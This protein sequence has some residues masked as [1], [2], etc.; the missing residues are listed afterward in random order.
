MKIEKSQIFSFVTTVL[1]FVMVGHF[2]LGVPFPKLHWVKSYFS[3]S[4]TFKSPKKDK[5]IKPSKTIIRATA[6]SND[7][8]VGRVVDQFNGVKVYSNGRVTNI[9]G[10]NVTKDGYNLGLKYQCVEFVKR[11]YYEYYHHK[12]PDSYGNAKDFFNFDVPDG[13]YNS[14]RGLYQFTN[15]SKSRPQVGDIIVFGPTPFNKFGHVAIV[16]DV[17]ADRMEIIQQNPGI[18]NPSR[19]WIGLT[20]TDHMY[21][22]DHSYVWGWLRK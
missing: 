13:E 9:H 15:P 4:P 1:I 8:P 22:V 2:F 14:A 18:G 17:R 3:G 10:R 5:K 19:K 6:G 20:Y 11:Y 16:S 12:M 21:Q 7:S